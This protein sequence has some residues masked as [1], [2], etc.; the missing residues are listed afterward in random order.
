[1]WNFSTGR[2]RRADHDSRESLLMLNEGET[3]KGLMKSTLSAV[4]MI[5]FGAAIAIAPA[6]AQTGSRVL[7]NI[8]FDFFVGNTSL[9]AGSYTIDQLESGVLAFSGND[10]QAHQFVLAVRGDSTNRKHQP[11]LLFTRYGTKTFL[12][13]V[14]L[15]SDNDCN[16]LLQSSSEKK[17]AQGAASGDELSLLIQPAR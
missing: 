11:N 17:V 2:K 1:M 15:S 8:P 16:R 6:H 13:A 10:Q 12:N 14:F 7:V 5:A 3:M 4:L 9:K